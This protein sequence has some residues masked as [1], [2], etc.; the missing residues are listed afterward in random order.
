MEIADDGDAVVPVDPLQ[1]VHDDAGVARVE[2]GDGLV[3][4]DDARLL[5]EGAGD[6][7]ALL[8]S[9]GEALGALGGKA[10]NVELLEGGEGDGLVLGAPQLQQ[11]AG[12]TDMVQPAHQHV[13]EDVEAADQVELLEDHGAG[14]AP[15][16]QRRALQAGDVLALAED[17]T[18]RWVL[19]AVDHAQ[20]RRLAGAR[21]AD[22]ADE[23]AAVDLEGHIVHRRHG[24]EAPRQPLDPQ[25]GTLP[26]PVAVTRTP[27]L[28]G[29]SRSGSLQSCDSPGAA[30]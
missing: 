29:G 13:G 25:H 20:Q 23:G 6:G 16:A 1:R 5:D 18:G 30:F 2:R 4:E 8:L 12:L 14:L 3:G 26:G 19:Q 10:G 9:A 27:T 15:V 7:D 17:A 28:S 24:A 22:H 11:R 21:A